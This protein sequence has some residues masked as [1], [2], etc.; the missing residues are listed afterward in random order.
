M[1]K[2]ILNAVSLCCLG[3]LHAVGSN[4]QTNYSFSVYGILNAMPTGLR[5]PNGTIVQAAKITTGIGAHD[6][7]SGTAGSAT[8]MGG[9]FAGNTLPGYVG[10]QTPTNFSIIETGN[11]NTVAGG[12]G[13]N[14]ANSIGFRVYFDRPTIK[15]SFLAVDIDGNNTNPGNAEWVSSMA[16]NGDV[17]V[18]YTQ[19]VAA[20]TNLATINITTSNAWKTLVTN[21]VSAIAAT[22]IPTTLSIQRAA[23]GG[24][25]PNDVAGQVLFNPTVPTAAITN[26]FGLWGLWQTPSGVNVQTSGF[27][28][29]VVRVSPDFGDCPD[30]YKTLLASGGPS[31]G[32]VGT[33]SLGVLNET[34]PDGQP[35][36]L[37]NLDVDDDGVTT[38]LP[39][40]INTNALTQTITSYSITS[41]FTNNTNSIANYVAWID[42]NNNGSFEASEAQVATSPAATTSGSV[43]FNWTNTQLTGASG[44]GNTYA[45]IRVTTEPITTSDVGGAFKDG[46]VEDYLVPFV[47]PLPL[48][49]TDFNAKLE[50]GHCQL[51]WQTATEK[52]TRYFDIEY[53]NNGSDFH[54]IDQIPAIGTG[55]NKYQYRDERPARNRNYYRLQMVDADGTAVYSK[56]ISLVTEQGRTFTISGSPNPVD[57]ILKL[58][59]RSDDPLYLE[60]Y[61]VLGKMVYSE[62]LQSADQTYLD[63]S[64]LIT[65]T[66]YLKASNSFGETKTII[67]LKK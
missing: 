49:L 65:G 2:S 15:I 20:T 25:N 31:H 16:F 7:A 57:Q 34:K 24:V 35:S 26:Y 27:S 37:A 8:N 29:I 23:G 14:C 47:V 21:T 30:S 36:A 13:N 54:K 40:I 62:K 5:L 39:A 42:W 66:Y 12:N 58:S 3:F 55:D 67:F 18:P 33:L 41:T 43:T 38:P 59:I 56:I 60:I 32:V 51:S 28:P 11:T 50:N 45:R 46:E 44:I 63:C 17:F 22:N 6:A 19:T 53:S 61:N 9:L 1:K 52:N 4:A 48:N 10:D 64:R